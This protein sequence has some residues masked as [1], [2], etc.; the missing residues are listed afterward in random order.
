M[1]NSNQ[2][3]FSDSLG[4]PLQLTEFSLRSLKFVISGALHINDIRL[5]LK[6]TKSRWQN[7]HSA[8]LKKMLCPRYI[9]FRIQWVESKFQERHLDLRLQSQLFSFIDNVW[10][11]STLG[12]F[13]WNYTQGIRKLKLPD[14]FIMLNPQISP[15]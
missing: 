5:I 3:L 14:R 7:L 10:R 8:K 12:K 4:F 11:V 13:Y 9:L 15:P 1:Q 2:N 6:A